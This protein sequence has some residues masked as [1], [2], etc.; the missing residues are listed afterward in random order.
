MTGTKDS[1]R[2]RACEMSSFSWAWFVFFTQIPFVLWYVRG[3]PALHPIVVMLPLVCM[4]N[5]MVER[6][7]P[8]GL[9]L[10]LM[11]PGRSIVLAA[12]FATFSLVGWCIGLIFQGAALNPPLL[13]T[14]VIWLLLRSFLVDVFVLALWEEFLNRGYIQT[15][16]QARWGFWGMVVTALLFASVHIP[17][18]ALD[19]DNDVVRILLRFAQT[20][21]VGFVLGYIYWQSGS[22]ITTIAV[23][24]LNNFVLSLIYVTGGVSP[25]ELIFSQAPFHFAWL[26]VQVG[27]TALVCRFLFRD[28]HK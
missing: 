18:A 24:G 3:G 13:T 25:Q 11:R 10:R 20:G 14:D 7:G 27:L 4:L 16:L 21:L 17:S 2:H 1:T 5:F 15:R 26:I 6:R 28:R 8:E 22:L 23:H 19:Y 9:G 12:G